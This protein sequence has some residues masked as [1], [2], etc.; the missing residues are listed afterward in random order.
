MISCV[1]NRIYHLMAG[2]DSGD[3]VGYVFLIL[4]VLV[5]CM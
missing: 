2:F 4:D 5:W 1:A 3:I